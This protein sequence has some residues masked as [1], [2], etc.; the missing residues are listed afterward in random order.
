MAKEYP[1]GVALHQLPRN[2]PGVE[3][4][5]QVRSAIMPPPGYLLVEFDASNQ[6]VRIAAEVSKCPVLTQV[7]KDNM[8]VHSFMGSRIAGMTYDDFMIGKKNKNPAIV[9]SNGYRYCGKFIVLG[10]LYRVGAKKARIV[11]RTQYG[12]NKDILTIKQW[13]KL[14]HHTFPGIKRYWKAAIEKAKAMGYA[15]TFADRRFYIDQWKREDMVWSCESNS[16]NHPIQGAGA[17]MSELAVAMMYR[18]FSDF[19]YAFNLHDGLFFYAPIQRGIE[20]RIL[21]AR[22]MLDALP[23]KKMWGWEPSIPFPW[24][25]AVG[26]SWGTTEEWDKE[27]VTLVMGGYSAY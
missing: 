27:K 9:G 19:L 15:T 2:K 10:S 1:S 5:K 11:A 14:Y 3:K 7:F 24:D 23:Y 4:D 13:Q 8:D 22:G 6:E 21:A 20:Q 12:L 18:Y 17:D 25:C 16:I 26:E